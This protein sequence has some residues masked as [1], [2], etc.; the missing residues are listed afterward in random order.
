MMET[1]DLKI[2]REQRKKLIKNNEEPIGLA[3]EK[4]EVESEKIIKD[5]A[6]NQLDTLEKEAIQRKNDKLRGIKT[7]RQNKKKES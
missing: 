1:N 6:L 5:K 7:K 2:T 3:M 4:Y